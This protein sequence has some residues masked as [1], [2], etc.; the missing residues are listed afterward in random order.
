RP[1]GFKPSAGNHACEVC[2]G[3]QVHITD[4]KHF[5]PS[6]VRL[7]I[8]VTIRAEYPDVFDWAA[9]REDR[10]HLDGQIGTSWS[11]PVIDDDARVEDSLAEERAVISHFEERRRPYLISG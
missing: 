11:R 7:T 5:D 3:A 6:R 2:G 9:P 8:L 4:M 1:H 10:Y